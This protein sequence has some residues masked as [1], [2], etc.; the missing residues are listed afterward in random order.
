MTS[1]SMVQ[2]EQALSDARTTLKKVNQTLGIVAKERNDAWASLDVLRGRLQEAEK[3]QA[4]GE[5]IREFLR[6]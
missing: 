6:D 3:G 4:L 1:M 2:L 5:A